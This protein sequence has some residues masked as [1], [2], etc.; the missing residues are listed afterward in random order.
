MGEY[1]QNLAFDG[2]SIDRVT[3]NNRGPNDS[4]GNPGRFEG[5]DTAWMVDLKFGNTTLEKRW[6]WWLSAGYR[7]V[8]SDA[9]IDGFTESDFGGGGTNL[10]GYTVAGALALSK[11]FALG[12]RWMS[13][14]EVA[15]PPF[16]NDILQIDL[17]GKF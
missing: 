12:I 3:V 6:D 9:V 14:E 8:E 16:K 5:G 15:G 7:Y 2:G 10:K 4:L 1:L 13:A 17:N 11:R